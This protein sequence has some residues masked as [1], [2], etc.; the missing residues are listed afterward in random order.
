MQPLK[1]VVADDHA[2]F[3][4]LLTNFLRAQGV[5]VVG[6]ATNGKEAV[7]QA[8]HCTPDLVLMDIS[9]PKLNGFEAARTI[10]R[11]HP[12]TKVIIVSSHTGDVYRKAALESMADGYIEKDS[13]KTALASLIAKERGS[14]RVAI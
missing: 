14:V 4:E 1:V 13:M 5:E 9:M 8:D 12:R 3:R 2:G 11:L 6:V 7:E 10:K